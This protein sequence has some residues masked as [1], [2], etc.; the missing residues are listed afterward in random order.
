MNDSCPPSSLPSK[1]IVR[2]TRHDNDGV[3]I[4]YHYHQEIP[5]G[6][7][8]REA[9]RR[10]CEEYLTR[11][12]SDSEEPKQYTPAGPSAGPP[13]ELEIFCQDINDRLFRDETV[14]FDDTLIRAFLDRGAMLYSHQDECVLYIPHRVIVA[15]NG[16]NVVKLFQG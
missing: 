3:E 16:P 4:Q 7:S 12:K 10:C 8:L 5:S 14:V 2:T 1:E 6:R 15:L 9:R 13:V 11:K